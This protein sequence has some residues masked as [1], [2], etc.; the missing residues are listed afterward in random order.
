MA[1]DDQIPQQLAT[2]RD[3]IEYVGG[4]PIPAPSNPLQEEARFAL[5]RLRSQLR[6]VL[7]VA[8]TEGIEGTE[9]E[10]L[11]RPLLEIGIT[12]GWIKTDTARLEALHAHRFHHLKTFMQEF[13]DAANGVPLQGKVGRD[14]SI[15]SLR[16]RARTA[17]LFYA[18]AYAMGYPRLSGAIHGHAD[19][20][21]STQPG[22]MAVQN[23]LGDALLGASLILYWIA[24]VFDLD[25]MRRYALKVIT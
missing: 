5:G 19:A 20:F 6:A 2:L 1:D 10:I 3:V 23:A 17:G 24:L 14:R 15:P 21:Q 18:D 7:V 11:A 8:T 9:V 13:V 22:Q 25:S 16:E 4:A 12:L